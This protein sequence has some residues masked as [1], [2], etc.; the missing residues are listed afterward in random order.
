MCL[1]LFSYQ[2]HP[3]YPLILAANRDEFYKRPT[4]NLHVW[5]DSPHIMAGQ[6]MRDGGTWLGM[7]P[8]GRFCA[9]TNVRETANADEVKSRGHLV[10]DFL[11]DNCSPDTYLREVAKN[12]HLFKGFNLLVGDNQAIYYY[13][14][15]AQ[16]IEQLAPG[17]YG[18]SNYLLNTPWPKVTRGLT[19]FKLIVEENLS[20]TALL[21]LL[22]DDKIAADALLPDTGIGIESE[23]LLSPLFIKSE[24]YGTRSSTIILKERTGNI[25]FTEKCFGPQGITL[26]SSSIVI[27]P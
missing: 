24:V 15:R 8:N 18:L 10:V 1:I 13:S 2:V 11:R 20:D 23:R 6:D 25:R 27:R 17:F 26:G 16:R 19:L 9:L 12:H 3:E 21:S 4:K 22:E 14:N 5:P 7:T